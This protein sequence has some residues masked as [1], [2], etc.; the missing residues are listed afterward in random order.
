A[1]DNDVNQLVATRILE[2]LGFEPHGVPNGREAVRAMENSDFDLVLMDVHMPDMD[3]LWA[4]RQIRRLHP[5]R[6]AVP[7]IAMTAS[8]M[9]GDREKCLESGMD[10][11]ISKPIN[12]NELRRTLLRWLSKTR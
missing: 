9:R 8:A 10:D 11:Y 5:P 7:I 1:E 2:K 3:G 4:T 12:R 6:G